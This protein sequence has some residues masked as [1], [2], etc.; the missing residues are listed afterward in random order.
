[1]KPEKTTELCWA[2]DHSDFSGGMSCSERGI[3][4][5]VE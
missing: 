3:G 2:I 1:M 4:Q 5:C